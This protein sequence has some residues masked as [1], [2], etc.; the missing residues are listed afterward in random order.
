MD[1]RTDP[2][3]TG[4]EGTLSESP[5]GH[6]NSGTTYCIRVAGVL[7]EEWSKRVEG[8][9][10]RICRDEG[11][12]TWTELVGTLPDQCALMGVLD[13]LHSYGATVLSVEQLETHG[14]GQSKSRLGQ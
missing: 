8:M 10:V 1:N 4:V 14:D 5:D 13:R 11:H 12:P 6:R 9:A 3:A 2:A 7:G